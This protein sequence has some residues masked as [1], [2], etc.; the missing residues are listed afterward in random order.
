MAASRVGYPAGRARARA[1]NWQGE[2]M[3]ATL[4]FGLKRPMPDAVSEGVF[5]IIRRVSVPITADQKS[6]R[7]LQIEEKI[8]TWN[9]RHELIFKAVF[10]INGAG[11]VGTSKKS[12]YSRFFLVTH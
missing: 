2:E 4:V 10:F 1:Q 8:L 12:N 9:S 7:L 3:R 6:R 11:L 5:L